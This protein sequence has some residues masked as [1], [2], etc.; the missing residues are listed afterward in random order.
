MSFKLPVVDFTCPDFEES[1]WGCNGEVV[2]VSSSKH[3]YDSVVL[4]SRPCRYGLASIEYLSILLS[5][6]SGA[7]PSRSLCV[8]ECPSTLLQVKVK[9]K[10]TTIHPAMPFTYNNRVPTFLYTHI[11]PF[12]ENIF[13]P[14]TLVNLKRYREDC[15]GPDPCTKAP[16][17]FKVS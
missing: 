4:Q 5:A 3:V 2:S 12:F 16:M 9:G 17:A 11:N 13:C 10:G 1:V 14:R 7:R 15:V 8:Y 6:F